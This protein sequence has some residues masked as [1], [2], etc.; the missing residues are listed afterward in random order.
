MAPM[1]E[2][3]T[4]DLID[5]EPRA[6]LRIERVPCMAVRIT[7]SGSPKESETGDAICATAWQPFTASSKAS[8]KITRRGQHQ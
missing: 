5:G 1:E 6:E 3:K 2:I 8:G 7:G 4:T